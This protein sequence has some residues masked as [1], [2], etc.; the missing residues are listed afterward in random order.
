MS[1]D[2][3]GITVMRPLFERV[4]NVIERNTFDPEIEAIVNDARRMLGIAPTKRPSQV[5]EEQAN[6]QSNA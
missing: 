2:P 6:Q 5:A 1:K 3:F 4:L